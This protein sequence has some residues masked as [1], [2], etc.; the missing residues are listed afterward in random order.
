MAER[1]VK[2]SDRQVWAV[3]LSAVADAVD[4]FDF[5]LSNRFPSADPHSLSAVEDAIYDIY[6]MAAA[7]AAVAGGGESTLNRLLRRMLTGEEGG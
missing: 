6:Q 7:A 3:A 4:D 2:L 1:T 5:D